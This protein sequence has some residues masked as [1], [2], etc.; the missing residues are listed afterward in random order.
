M[1]QKNIQVSFL[2]DTVYNSNNKCWLLS[3]SLTTDL[4]VLPSHSLTDLSN[5]ALAMSRASGE[6]TTSLI[7]CMCPVMRVNDLQLVSGVHKNIV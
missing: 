2:L 7:C 5:D 1:L 3:Q 4:P 6:N